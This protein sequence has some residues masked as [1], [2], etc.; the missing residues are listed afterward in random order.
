MDDFATILNDTPRTSK[1][2]SRD[3]HSLNALIIPVQMAHIR[4]GKV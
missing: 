2:I 1:F 3:S 4:A